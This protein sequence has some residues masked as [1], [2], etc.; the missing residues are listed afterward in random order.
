MRSPYFVGKAGIEMAAIIN[1][2]NFSKYY[3]DYLAVEDVSFE[4]EKG[5][6]FAFLGPNGAGKSTTINALC[7][8]IDKTSGVLLIDGED[9]SKQRKKVRKAIGIVFQ[10]PTLDQQMTVQENLVTH[11]ILYGVPR[12]EIGERI[13]IL[14]D[15]V[16]LLEWQNSLVSTLSGG[17]KRR[18]E[19]V[20]ALVHYPKI[21]FLDEPTTGLDP[22]TRNR[23]WEYIMKLQ[24]EKNI[25][26][27]LTTHYIEEAEVCDRVA[28]MDDGK[29]IVN[30]TP[31][32]L[33]NRY[34]KTRAVLKMKDSRKAEIYLLQQEFRYEKK[35]GYLHLEVDDME[36]FIEAIHSL[37]ED[38]LDLEVTKGS[39]NDVF[40]EITGK[41]I[42]EGG[43]AG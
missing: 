19:I 20:R 39:L 10:E 12:N 28:I 26:I 40:L 11:C 7:T 24:K 22:Q 34:T 31:Q 38:V 43:D 16:D 5:S 17:M 35:G 29:I 14:L 42:R 18:V 41:K 25:T 27:F 13:G 8:M 21:L 36:R 3:G 32:A 6:S 2:K 37:K 33:K 15:L 1:V 30:D 4:V 23:M 9:V